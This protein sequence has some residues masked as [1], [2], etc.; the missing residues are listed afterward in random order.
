[1]QSQYLHAGGYCM[2]ENR[3]PL[4]YVVRDATVADVAALDRCYDRANHA[5]RI[6][7]ADGKAC[8]YVVVEVDGEV[9]G[10][11]RLWLANPP[12]P[13]KEANSPYVPRI[14]NL[15]VRGDMR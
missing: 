14:C 2:A 12:G 1:M 9:V 8:R 4:N 6:A 10:F 7:A 11:G 5:K 15:N 13:P 3:P